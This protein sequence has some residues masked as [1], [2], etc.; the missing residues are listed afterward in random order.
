MR[1]V[2]LYKVMK[3]MWNEH[4]MRSNSE[5]H[6]GDLLDIVNPKISVITPSLNH[7]RFLRAT[8]ES[9]ANQKYRSFEHI[10]IDG[11]SND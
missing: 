11:G 9:V 5:G 3:Y 2:S 1:H 10:V 6:Y 7:G 8:I 4:A